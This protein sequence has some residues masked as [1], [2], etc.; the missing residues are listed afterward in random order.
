M[1]KWIVSI[2][3]MALL[4]GGAYY[5]LADRG[6]EEPARPDENAPNSE[7]GSDEAA[8]LSAFNFIL[9]FIKVAPPELDEESI[10]QIM[11]ALS[12]NAKTK[13]RRETIASDLAR[14]VGVQDVPDQG[15]SVEDLKIV[16]P[17]EAY[18][19]VGLNYSGGRVLRNVHLV[20]EGG[21]WKVD[22][23]STPAAPAAM[24]DQEGNL[25]RN[26]PGMKAGVWYLVYEKP[27]QPA[28][29]SE[30]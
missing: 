10:N 5:W 1:N 9:S 26:N 11:G 8:E 7:I 18:L 27:G 25:V 22:R 14:F 15:A 28:L 3:V 16:S 24:F 21:E 19:V 6:A 2:I 30:L 17:T 23:V 20:K 29:G 13:I 4:A 12:S